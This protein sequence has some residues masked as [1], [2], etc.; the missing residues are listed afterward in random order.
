MKASVGDLFGSKDD[1]A[2]GDNHIV[3][4]TI[5]FDVEED[6][7]RIGLHSVSDGCSLASDDCHTDSTIVEMPLQSINV[8]GYEGIQCKLQQ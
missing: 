6:D 7:R 8:P 5:V 4:D 3:S 2:A 1:D